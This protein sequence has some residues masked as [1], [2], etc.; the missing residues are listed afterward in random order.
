MGRMGRM[1]PIKMRWQGE[2]FV[3]FCVQGSVVR[4]FRIA[5]CVFGWAAHTAWP[6]RRAVDTDSPQINNELFVSWDEHGIGGGTKTVQ[7]PKNRSLN[8]NDLGEYGIFRPVLNGIRRA[9]WGEK[10]ENRK[11][12]TFVRPF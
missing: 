1:G 4:G 11:G 12:R 7:G 8:I 3:F 2:Y 5:C 9:S 6:N 10:S